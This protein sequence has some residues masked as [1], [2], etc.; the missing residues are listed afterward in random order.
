MNTKN[1]KMLNRED[2]E[3]SFLD[4]KKP[5]ILTSIKN[6]FIFSV[7]SAIN[8]VEGILYLLVK[9]FLI[10]SFLK[11]NLTLFLLLLLMCISDVKL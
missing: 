4:Y 1:S 7:F 8:F 11:I 3:Q 10:F 9:K 2:D 6:T 5:K